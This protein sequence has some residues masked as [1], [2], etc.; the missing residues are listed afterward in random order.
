MKEIRQSFGERIATV[1]KVEE[2][3]KQETKYACYMLL[4]GLF[5]GLIFHPDDNVPS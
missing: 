2:L 1:I 5:L 4:A 3:S